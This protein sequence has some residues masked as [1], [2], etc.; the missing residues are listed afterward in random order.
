M[1]IKTAF[2]YRDIDEDIW[3]ELPI[4]YG[5]SGIAKLRKALYGL[6]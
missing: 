2:L 1:D 3:I 6:K 4:G 5:V